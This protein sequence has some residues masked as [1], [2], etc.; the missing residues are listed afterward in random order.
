MS[1]VDVIVSLERVRR[2]RVALLSTRLEVASTLVSLAENSADWPK[3]QRLEETARRAFEAVARDFLQC[4]LAP[5]E[6]EHFTDQFVSLS[7]RLHILRSAAPLRERVARREARARLMAG[8]WRLERL[9][10]PEPS[11][12][13]SEPQR[14]TSLER[15]PGDLYPPTYSRMLH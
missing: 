7:K 14:E 5:S 9:D 11:V 1:A 10:E 8:C 12:T 4:R 6:I 13:P 15:R 2:S 3:A